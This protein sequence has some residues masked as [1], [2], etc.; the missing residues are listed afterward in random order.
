ML[1]DKNYK[2]IK[3]DFENSK[4]G[5]EWNEHVEILVYFLSFFLFMF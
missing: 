2:K 4:L 1:R 5:E 3:S